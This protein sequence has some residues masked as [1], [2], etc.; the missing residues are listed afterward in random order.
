MLDQLLRNPVTERVATYLVFLDSRISLGEAFCGVRSDHLRSSAMVPFPYM[1]QHNLMQHFH[2]HRLM[3]N[4]MIIPHSGPYAC[5]L[6]NQGVQLYI[7][8]L[9]G[10]VVFYNLKRESEWI[11]S[12]F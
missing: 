6:Y 12:V 3:K 8:D 7:F 4:M 9:V 10:P 1:L 11:P 5:G 2:V